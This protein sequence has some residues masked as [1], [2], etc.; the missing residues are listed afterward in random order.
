MVSRDIVGVRLDVDAERSSPWPAA[1]QN[2]SLMRFLIVGVGEMLGAVLHNGG[3][4][5]ARFRA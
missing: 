2:W 4:V 5:T 1:A 3:P